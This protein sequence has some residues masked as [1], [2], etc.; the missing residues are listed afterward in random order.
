M[1]RQSRTAQKLRSLTAGRATWGRAMVDRNLPISQRM[2]PLTHTIGRDQTMTEA[3]RRMHEFDI[4][5]LAV[6]HA[7]RMLGIV[8]E[9]DIA[10]VETLPSVDPDVVQVHEAMTPEPYTVPAT[11][12]LVDVVEEM[13]NHKYGAALVLDGAALVGIFTTTDALRLAHDLLAES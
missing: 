11:A 9:R 2:S 4:R 10:M 8:S 1:L 7:G 12:K 13:A 5:H 3:R 6:L